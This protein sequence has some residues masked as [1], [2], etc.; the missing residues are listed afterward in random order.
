V[1]QRNTG[2]LQI[3][4]GLQNSEEVDLGHQ[5]DDVSLGMDSMG[6]YQEGVVDGG[7]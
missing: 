6:E 2:R 1:F 5:G 7:V 3:E 4:L